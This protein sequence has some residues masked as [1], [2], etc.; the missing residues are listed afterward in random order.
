MC[1]PFEQKVLF[2]VDVTDDQEMYILKAWKDLLRRVC[3]L[4]CFFEGIEQKEQFAF[5]MVRSKAE[6]GVA[7]GCW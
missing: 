6:I 2:V 4:P 5:T 7:C 1:H 3:R